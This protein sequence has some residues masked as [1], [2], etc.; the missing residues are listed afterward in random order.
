MTTDRKA[1][2]ADVSPDDIVKDAVVA[3]VITR[4]R[5]GRRAYFVAIPIDA[6]WEGEAGSERSGD[7]CEIVG[8]VPA[9]PGTYRVWCCPEEEGECLELGYELPGAYHPDWVELCR[10][11][12]AERAG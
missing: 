5:I 2:G 1:N 7:G 11:K 3:W 8:V 9:Q 6:T 12:L 10:E 4:C